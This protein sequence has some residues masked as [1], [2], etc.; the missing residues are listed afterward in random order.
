MESQAEYG[1]RL[2]DEINREHAEKVGV[3][4]D[5]FWKQMKEGIETDDLGDRLG[6]LKLTGKLNGWEPAE[7]HEHSGA[8]IIERRIIGANKEGEDDAI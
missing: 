2:M 8:V 3:T 4:L 5:F 7:K 1:K 6:Y